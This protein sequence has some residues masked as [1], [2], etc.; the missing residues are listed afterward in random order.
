MKNFPHQ[1][2]DLT[3]LFNALVSIKELIE[4][5]IALK[6]ENFGELLTRKEIYTYRDKNLSIDEFLAAEEQKPKASRGYLTVAR[7]I[8]RLFQLL[9][10]LVVYDDKSGSLSPQAIQLITAPNDSIKKELWKNSFLQL[11]LEGTDGE[12]SHPYRILLKLVQEI[13]GIE[14]KKLML[15]LEAENDSNEEYQRILALA[16]LSYEDILDSTGTS[17]SMAKNAVKILPGIAEQLDDIERKGNNSYSIGRVIITEDEISTEIPEESTN[18]DGIPY[19]QFRQVTSADI[20]K[21]PIFNNVSSVSI[22]LTES[23]RIRQNRL[24]QHQE[25]VRQLGL[26]CEENGFDLYEGKFDCLSTMDDKAIVFEV[27]TIQDSMSD[28]EKQTIKGVGQLKYYKF[29]I[30]HKQMGYENTKEV[31]VYSQK[32]KDSL[33]E[34]CSSENISISWIENGHFKIYDSESNSDLD[35]EPINFI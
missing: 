10:F 22:D 20:A 1:F 18:R 13:P 16:N 7:D 8:R 27:K 15:A 31:L 3:K 26:L 6:D 34:F 9:G 28:Q 33:I 19:S 32:P 11:G 23:I 21:D 4:E 2:N 24:A 30:V 35:F 5:E 25:I 29:S 17:E 14:T 12:I